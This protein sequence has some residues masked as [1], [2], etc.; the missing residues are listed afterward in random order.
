MRGDHH[1]LARRAV[2]GVGGA[3]RPR[4]SAC[5]RAPARR[6]V[7]AS[8][9]QPLRRA[10]S[11]IS[12]MLPFEQGARRKRR[13]S[14]ARPGVTSGQASRR[15]QAKFSCTR[16]ASSSVV[17]AEGL[18]HARRGCA[19][20]AR[21][22]WRTAG[23]RCA[24]LP[25]PAGTGRARRRRRPRRR[26]RCL[27][28]RAAPCT[29]RAIEPSPVDQRA[30]HVE[31]Q[32][33]HF[34][35]GR[36]IAP[37]GHAR[38]AAMPAFARPFADCPDAALRAGGRRAH[39]HRRHADH[40]RR[41]HARRAAG[42]GRPARRRPAGDR[43]HR[44]TDGLERAL[45]A[46]LAGRRHRRRERRGGA[47][48]GRRPRCTPS[49]RRT[50]PRASPTRTRL[51]QAAQRV[52]REVPGAT[53]AQRQRRREHR[54]RHRPQRVRAPERRSASTQ[55]VA[56]MRERGPERHRQLHPHQRLV[57]RARQAARRA[58]DRARPAGPRPRR[59]DASAGSTWATRPTTS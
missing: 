10:R 32:Q 19:G 34:V 31:E 44:P 24:L 26:P 43:H 47:V 37:Q 7:I 35:H 5:S 13:R 3:G 23:G 1:R 28:R 15:C 12:E 21:R 41:H 56:I 14:R 11:A 49:T 2:E 45:C 17:E 29:S 22:A 39:R 25:S 18:Q 33:L 42:A 36:S 57:R 40:R 51:P 46:R 48:R 27:V 9:C 16:V 53:L 59:R 55:V 54:H 20:A 4:P 58:L 6:R 50:R 30:E 52:L 8:Q 38:L